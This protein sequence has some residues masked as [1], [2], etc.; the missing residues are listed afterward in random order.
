[1][2]D[3][4]NAHIHPEHGRGLCRRDF[5]KAGALALAG[6]LF[7]GALYAAVKGPLGLE[8]SLDLY[9]TH[10]GERLKTVYWSGGRYLPE[11]LSEINSILR[12]HRTE[13]TRPM[14]TGLLDVLHAIHHG[15][16]SGEPLHI[17]SGYRSPITNARLRDHSSGVARNSLHME[18]KA[19][20]IRLPGC[21]LS[22]LRSIAMS[23]KAGGV[24]YYPGSDFI[25]VDV[26]RVRYW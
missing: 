15:A 13:E 2:S 3:G 4:T 21:N 26:G 24:G 20:D 14:D 17:I 9:N 6:C 1:M 25:H 18:A 12:D 11:A 22:E 19:A 5:L 16:C 23:L 7:P 10:T 8:R